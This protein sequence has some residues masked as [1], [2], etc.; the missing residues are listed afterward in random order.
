MQPETPPSP[1]HDNVYITARFQILDQFV[2]RSTRL[3]ISW[4]AGFKTGPVYTKSKHGS[5]SW[6]AWSKS[7]PAHVLDGLAPHAHGQQSFMCANESYWKEA[8]KHNLWTRVLF[9]LVLALLVSLASP[10]QCQCGSL[11]VSNPCWC[12][13]GLARLWCLLCLDICLYASANRSVSFHVQATGSL[14]DKFDCTAFML[15]RLLV[16][17]SAS[18]QA[19]RPGF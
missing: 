4:L 16:N 8:A 3:I 13:L 10:N 7:G 17:H 19:I 14:F 9:M 6:H 5:I 12:W 1:I 11:S 15:F 18:F 2:N